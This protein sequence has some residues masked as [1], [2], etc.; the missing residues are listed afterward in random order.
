[1]T[2]FRRIVATL[3]LSSG[4]VAGACRRDKPVQPPQDSTRSAPVTPVASDSTAAH[5]VST[6]DAGAGSILLVSSDAPTRAVV[7]LPTE[8]D[9]TT[10][11]ALPHPASATLLGRGGD[12]Q[13]ADFPSVRDSAGC[14]IASLTAAPPPHTWNVGFVGGVVAPLSVDS[15]ASITHA[16]SVQ[17]VASLNRLASVIPND[18]AGRF[19]GLPFVV[20]SL[21]RVFVAD[22]P[23]VV[24][25]ALVRQINQEATPLQE[26]TFIVGE[27]RGI[28]TAFTMGYS[29]RSYGQEE[30]V[31]SRELLAAVLIGDTKTPAIVLSRDYGDENAYSILERGAD[32]RWRLRWTSRRRH[33]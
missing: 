28:D 30:T 20:Q 29:E 4:I 19:T 8:N 24:A 27:R 23:T 33:C 18:S 12:V 17:L 6:W 14:H 9:S 1:M 31:E 13:T 25:G 16:D 21:W 7:V 5:P 15:A 32:G 11:G 10:L 2:Q 22:G 3:S 26:R